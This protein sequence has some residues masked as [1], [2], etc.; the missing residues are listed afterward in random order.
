MQKEL[1]VLKL[2]KKYI[3]QAYTGRVVIVQSEKDYSRDQSDWSKLSTHEVK[4]HAVPETDHLNIIR[5]PYISVWAK[6]L[7]M[8]LRRTKAN[9]KG[10]KE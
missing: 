5:N 2:Q 1:T 4:I 8:Y 10:K 3:F 6:W 7:N 9:N